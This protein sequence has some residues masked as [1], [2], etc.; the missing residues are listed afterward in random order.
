MIQ[1][2]T[3][4]R[5]RLQG[6]RSGGDAGPASAQPKRL[7]L[8][9]YLAVMARRSPVRRDTLLALFWPELG[10]DEARRALRQG[11]HYLR[12]VVGEDAL[13]GTGEELSVSDER[14]GCDAVE[15]E[16]LIAAGQPA[17]ALSLYEG[18]FLAGFHVPDVSA[19][20]EEWVDRTR[21]RLRRHA[22]TAAW[23]AADAAESSG[24]GDQ[25]VA[26]GR[27]ACELE[28]DQE[29]GW[30]RLMTLQDRLGDRAG[31]L[32][33]HDE[34][35]A[36][37]RREFDADPSTETAALAAKLRAARV[38]D[39]PSPAAEPAQPRLPSDRPSVLPTSVPSRRSSRP[40]RWRRATACS[41]RTSSMPAGTRPSRWR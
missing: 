10:D 30:R 38:S 5:V 20:Y 9:A 40:A 22:A 23:A 27:R 2:Q 29:G 31:A 11:L 19:E 25:A 41:S 12:R 13:V 24:Q 33:T 17:Q 34:L 37:L 39:A 26:F 3:L 28:P 14:F 35:A 15:F 7:A 8:L 16:R 18:D 1:L 6:D 21:A 4:G 36:R 32:R